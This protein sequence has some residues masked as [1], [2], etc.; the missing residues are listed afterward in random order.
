MTYLRQIY[1]FA[2]AKAIYR[3]TSDLKKP[4]TGQDWEQEFADADRVS[5]FL[6]YYDSAQLNNDERYA[7]MELIVASF[8]ELLA[9]G[10]RNSEWQARIVEHQT[11]RFNLFNDLVQYWAGAAVCKRRARRSPRC[12][13]KNGTMIR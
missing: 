13:G 1:R 10:K 6:D 2:S 5:D 3:V 11:N 7:L 9:S 12:M 4:A 8:D